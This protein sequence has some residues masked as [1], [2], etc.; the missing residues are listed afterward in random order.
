MLN[1]QLQNMSA[2]N[3]MIR[4]RS[5]YL[6][7]ESL[8]QDADATSAIYQLSEPVIAKDGFDL[9][10]GVRGFGFNASATN[11][12]Q[13]QRNNRLRIEVVYMPPSY[14]PVK[15]AY[16]YT[17][18]PNY[19]QNMYTI[20]YDVLFPC[21]LYSV[22]ELFAML[23]NGLNYY[24]PSGYKMDVT[25]GDE[26]ILSSGVLV[27]N[28]IP[29]TMNFQRS[30]GGYTLTPNYTGIILAYYQSIDS[31]NNPGSYYLAKDVNT[32]PM[33]MNIK[34]S[35]DS[36]E[37]YNLLFTN[38][39]ATSLQHI[40]IVPD[41]EL[42]LDGTNPPTYIQFTITNDV[43]AAPATF[44]PID[45][46]PSNPQASLMDTIQ[47]E[48]TTFP[49]TEI[50]NKL[51]IRYPTCGFLRNNRGYRSYFL[52]SIT[53]LYVEVQ[54]DLETTNISSYGSR[55]GIL[56]R[57]FLLGGGNGGTSFYQAYDTPVWMKMSGSRE[58]L[59]SMK[60]VFESEG[61]KWDFFNMN[62]FL[63][64]VFFEIAKQDFNMEEMQGPNSDGMRLPPNDEITMAMGQTA[65]N[66]FPFRRL[67]QDS[68]IAIFKDLRGAE[69]KRSRNN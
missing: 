62:F 22:D 19:N 58:Y 12:S 45:T 63:E 41:Y 46:P 44:S 31:N 57:Q 66:P 47:F 20:T 36:P 33:Y 51:N 37:L 59:D 61:K 24:I 6:T 17:F 60:V 54:S 67:N 56:V 23:S 14:L 7:S 64:L 25:S 13:K 9:V 4:P 11:I 1:N 26:P 10:F 49:D 18:A 42:N 34:P 39:N 68:G 2:L 48:T 21:G 27:P 5:V 3:T 52:P 35:P 32:Q 8:N 16:G 29:L 40:A 65:H 28:S 43:G 69:L 53:P 30:D 15:N 38:V 50:L 55:R